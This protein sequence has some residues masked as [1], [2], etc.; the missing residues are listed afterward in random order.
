MAVPY[1][2]PVATPLR[3]AGALFGATAALL[4]LLVAGARPWYSTWGA[5]AEEQRARPEVAVSRGL[6]LQEV[7]TVPVQAPAEQVFP[8]LA[9]LGQDRA[10]FYS[11]D[12]LENLVG[13]RMPRIERLD[14]SLQHWSI[15]DRLWMYPQDEL[16]GAGYARLVEYRPGSALVFETRA[17]GAGADAPASG[18][19]SLEVRATGPGS[20]RLIASSFGSSPTSLLGAVFNRA[21]FEP[22][23]F[24]MERRMLKGIAGLAE[25]APISAASDAVMLG[26]WALT[27]TVFITSA[28]L[29]LLGW[30]WRLRLLTLVLVGLAFQ[31][32]TLEQ[33][34]LWIGVPL[35]AGLLLLLAWAPRR[36]SG[37]Q[38]R[39][40]A[41]VI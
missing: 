40:L 7:R 24:A 8:W 4:G 38:L 18:L 1:F 13:C 36:A 31:V 5:S 41:P 39:Q 17:P 14:P 28:L 33:P 11:Y 26:L 12:L 30:R 35:V 16:G 37:D 2:I 9:Q 25:G 6:Q 19:W 27:L 20:S 23:H 22:M 34:S 29:V 21:V 10:G 15:G 32:L 3:R